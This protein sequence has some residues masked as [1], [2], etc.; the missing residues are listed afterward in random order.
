MD[1]LTV[2]KWGIAFIGAIGGPTLVANLVRAAFPDVKERLRAEIERNADLMAKLPESGKAR[3]ILQGAIEEDLERLTTELREARRDTA[4]IV[5]G[6]I[7]GLL[8]IMA[9]VWAWRLDG[10]WQTPVWI[11]IGA[12]ALSSIAL[13]AQGAPQ[14]LRD[15][16]GNPVSKPQSAIDD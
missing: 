4:S 6:I 2:A 8:A 7:F 14:T 3:G 11:L 5:V 15:E 1:I 10:W 9:I 12:L 13:V 16:K